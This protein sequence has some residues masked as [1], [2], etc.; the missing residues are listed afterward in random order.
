MGAAEVAGLGGAVVGG[1]G[2]RLHAHVLREQGGAWCLERDDGDD[3]VRP[4]VRVQDVLGVAQVLRRCP[5]AVL[6]GDVRLLQAEAAE[7]ARR[8]G[9]FV[10][11]EGIDLPA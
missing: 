11:R 7:L 9:G 10:A 1:V 8:D 3:G 2:L 5:A 6:I 4:A